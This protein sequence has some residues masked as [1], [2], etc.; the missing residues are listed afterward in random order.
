MAATSKIVEQELKALQE[1]HEIV[2]ELD[3]EASKNLNRFMSGKV[4][5]SP[6]K[7]PAEHRLFVTECLLII[8][9]AVK[10]KKR[11]RKPNV[12]I[13]DKDSKAS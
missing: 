9:R 1:I 12:V 8:A 3:P 11:G 5:P 2:K 10:G 4:M 7:R 13:H 6:T